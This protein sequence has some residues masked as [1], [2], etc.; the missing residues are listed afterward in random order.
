M[1]KMM[2]KISAIAVMTLAMLSIFAFKPAFISDIPGCKDFTYIASAEDVEDGDGDADGGGAA[3]GEGTEAFNDVVDFFATW[4]GRVGA[5]VAFVGGIMFA[6]AIKN[7]DAEQ[8]QSGLLTLVAG[9]V[10]VAICNVKI[11]FGL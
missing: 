3:G 8:K 9:F 10:V 6:L 7:N 2:K 1:K 4:L 11:I 5:L